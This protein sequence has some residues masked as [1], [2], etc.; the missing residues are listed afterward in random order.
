MAVPNLTT[1]SYPDLYAHLEGIVDAI[2]AHRAQPRGEF[3]TEA[4]H[5]DMLQRTAANKD[6]TT[7][8]DAIDREL[9]R[10][11]TQAAQVGATAQAM[12]TGRPAGVDDLAAQVRAQRY[13]TRTKPV[14]DKANDADLLGEVMRLVETVADEDLATV[15][16]E[17]PAYLTARGVDAGELIDQ[18]LYR[19]MPHLAEVKQAEDHARTMRTAFSRM[20]GFIR[21]LTSDINAPMTTAAVGVLK[22]AQVRAIDE[23]HQAKGGPARQA[24]RAA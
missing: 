22:L 6:W 11:I 14:L 23:R 21:E 12:L 17:L 5:T 18:A 8:A 2:R 4:G 10:R 19:R 3:L 13:W 7:D 24:D 9:A 20:L 15:L 1:A 16:E